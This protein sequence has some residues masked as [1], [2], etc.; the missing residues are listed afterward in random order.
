MTTLVLVHG[1]GSSPQVFAGWHDTF[2]DL[3]LVTPD[4]H[5]GLDVA[6]ATM[7]AYSL[8]IVRALQTH[9]R[10]LV[11][12]G[13][14]MG[15]LVAAMAATEYD[16]DA[17]VLLEPSPPAETQGG[18]P[19]VHVESGTFDPQQAYGPFP[20]GIVARNES[21]PARGE[22]KRGISVPSFPKH[23]L[24]VYGDEFGDDR[25]RAIAAHYGCEQLHVPGATHWDL[26]L[27]P[28]CRRRVA[29]Y[30]RPL[31]LIP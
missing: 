8:Q 5:E 15:G 11:L 16:V 25:G 10:P 31:G 22:R 29:D 26:V 20:A 27:E 17:L 13:W 4:L 28:D 6:T 18:D 3:T 2:G 9:S 7:G 30:L 19:R 1:A 21:I 24:V 23:T 12:C 14:S